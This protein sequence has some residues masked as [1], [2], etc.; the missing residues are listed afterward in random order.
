MNDLRS[1][2]EWRN[3][4]PRV[5]GIPGVRPDAEVVFN[6]AGRGA[7]ARL[8]RVDPHSLERALPAWPDGPEAFKE[9][10]GITQPLARWRVEPPRVRWRSQIVVVTWGFVSSV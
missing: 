4:P 8:C 10:A 7:L 6:Q 5:A 1:C 9:P 3:Q 2:W